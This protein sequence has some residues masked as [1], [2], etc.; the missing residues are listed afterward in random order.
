MEF[1][2]AG[3]VMETT[4]KREALLKAIQAELE[5]AYE[6]TLADVLKLLKIREKEEDE[7][8]I[9]D[10]LAELEDAKIN[11]TITW[12]EYKRESA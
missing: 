2:I 3:T 6:D 5:N 9:R 4:T 1:L 10:A 8:D 7:E 11:G 12:E